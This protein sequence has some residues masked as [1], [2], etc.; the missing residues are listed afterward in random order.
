MVSWLDDHCRGEARK[1]KPC[2]KRLAWFWT[3]S[4]GAAEPDNGRNK[5]RQKKPMRM[6]ALGECPWLQEEFIWTHVAGFGNLHQCENTG[7]FFTPL[8]FTYVNR[9]QFG[10]FR[11]LFLAQ[12]G[13]F[14]AMANSLANDFLTPPGF[15]GFSGK[16]E[17]GKFNTVEQ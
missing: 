17:A 2:A 3:A 10:S 6:H 8:Q 16:R 5:A 9:M 11:Q 4:T 12:F 13:E 14:S 7:S 1:K 15:A